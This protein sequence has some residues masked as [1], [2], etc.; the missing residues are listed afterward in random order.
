[1][2]KMSELVKRILHLTPFEVPAIHDCKSLFDL[3]PN[4]LVHHNPSNGMSAIEVQ[5][6]KLIRLL[7]LGTHHSTASVAFRQ[8]YRD[9]TIA[10]K[11]VLSKVM[12]LSVNTLSNGFPTVASLCE[13]PGAEVITV[14]EH[15]S[16]SAPT[17]TSACIHNLPRPVPASTDQPQRGV[18]EKDDEQYATNADD[19]DSSW[20]SSAMPY[21]K[22]RG[23]STVAT[24]LSDDSVFDSSV[25]LR[26]FGSGTIE[27][28]QQTQITTEGHH[29]IHRPAFI[30][31][32]SVA[33]N[34][35]P[36]QPMTNIHTFNTDPPINNEN[37][38]TADTSSNHAAA[39][40]HIPIDTD[41]R[42]PDLDD[43][44]DI[45]SLVFGLS[46]T[47]SVDHQFDHVAL[48]T[49][50][51]PGS[52][53]VANPYQCRACTFLYN[54][55]GLCP[56]CSGVPVRHCTK[57]TV[58]R[59]QSLFSALYDEHID[60]MIRGHQ[61]KAWCNPDFAETEK[62][63]EV[64]YK[65]GKNMSRLQLSLADAVSME[66]SGELV[67]HLA[68]SRIGDGDEGLHRQHNEKEMIKYHHGEKLGE[69]CCKT[70]QR[71]RRG[72]S[73]GQVGKSV[74]TVKKRRNQEY[75][76]GH[77]SMDQGPGGVQFDIL[78]DEMAGQKPPSATL[79]VTDPVNWRKHH[80]GMVRIERPS[81]G[82]VQN[83]V[84]PYADRF[85]HYHIGDVG[86]AALDKERGVN[87]DVVSNSDDR[88]FDDGRKKHPVVINTNK[89][90]F[91]NG[92]PYIDTLEGLFEEYK[93]L[94][95]EHMSAPETK[96]SKES[97]SVGLN[98]GGN[99]RI[100]A[101]RDTPHGRMPGFMPNGS[102]GKFK[103]WCAKMSSLCT[104]GVEQAIKQKHE[105][106]EM[107][108]IDENLRSEL[109]SY[110]YTL[111]GE[112]TTPYGDINAIAATFSLNT[113]A[114][115]CTFDT[116]GQCKG[117]NCGG[118][119]DFDWEAW[120]PSR[121]RK[122]N[123]DSVIDK[124]VGHVPLTWHVDK[125]NDWRKGGEYISTAC[126]TM[127]MDE[128][129]LRSKNFLLS[130]YHV[131]IDLSATD[132][133]YTRAVTRSCIEK[134]N[135]IVDHGSAAAK[136]I[137]QYDSS[138]GQ[139]F[140]Y[141]GFVDDDDVL[142]PYLKSNLKYG[143]NTLVRSRQ[144][145]NE[146]GQKQTS[147]LYPVTYGGIFAT[148]P[149]CKDRMLYLGKDID[150]YLTLV[151]PIAKRWEYRHAVQVAAA[152][153]CGYNSGQM[154]AASIM[155]DWINNK[156][157]IGSVYEHFE[158]NKNL[159]FF[160]LY[161]RSV[162]SHPGSKH[163]WV[164]E[165]GGSTVSRH[166]QGV[167]LFYH[168]DNVFDTFSQSYEQTYSKDC[169]SSL[170]SDEFDVD[171][172]LHELGR[173]SRKYLRLGRK[174]LYRTGKELAKE[175]SELWS[176]NDV[177]VLK[178]IQ[179]AGSVG[180]I[181]TAFADWADVGGDNCGSNK[182]LKLHDDKRNGTSIQTH[183]ITKKEREKK[184][185]ALH[186]E[187]SF[188]P[189]QTLRTT[190]GSMCEGYRRH[191]ASINRRAMRFMDVIF[192]SMQGEVQNFFKTA[193]Q[194][195]VGSDNR[196]CLQVLVGGKWRFVNDLLT[197]FCELPNVDANTTMAYAWSR[198]REAAATPD[199][200]RHEKYGCFKKDGSIR[201]VSSGRFVPVETIKSVMGGKEEA[202]EL[203]NDDEIDDEETKAENTEGETIEE[204]EDN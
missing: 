41:I 161:G 182:Y 38:A 79:D 29:G 35:Q 37:E 148:R 183:K 99:G 36:A 93:Y 122:I 105:G 131:G 82:K 110:C 3:I 154:M 166:C 138:E 44:A 89:N 167:G 136:M 150:N 118:V 201:F 103:V 34:P 171:K 72:L 165:M 155:E 194:A 128:I 198:Q 11:L 63:I 87:T 163:P 143:E 145:E 61:G 97:N 196:R 17:S 71:L 153:T 187:L 111:T 65:V 141:N 20:G 204:A 156:S 21:L 102:D 114:I 108:S 117:D 78:K 152:I 139:H 42:I 28:M 140:C 157:P 84:T 55:E 168:D 197:F 64:C 116:T 33:P 188:H 178:Y 6:K 85:G 60:V 199:W 158:E 151:T 58:I 18:I 177:S 106:F 50:V 14:P 31:I 19:D 66:D 133:F 180:I 96:G 83:Y 98:I 48:P 142:L 109:N 173:I 70:L 69:E 45:D 68:S 8:G 174:N 200:V 129:P 90:Y 2:R 126:A 67:M 112:E 181:D 24:T 192:L 104:H 12:G 113:E 144:W 127:P 193:T 88:L 186:G 115:P 92:K 184:F 175:V 134:K 39:T 57:S 100:S 13:S 51:C 172:W 53:D 185:I 4:D 73:T 52:V 160:K 59:E 120:E 132:I 124:S 101:W 22:E 91:Y 159:N 32:P 23:N 149:A 9:M 195:R 46:D 54:K 5:V 56:M 169:W 81:R 146:D 179:F 15:A 86:G 94:I 190:E 170:A 137:C 164:N 27:I 202:T 130:H 49:K 123:E 119:K 80:E 16:G 147:V 74:G 7:I 191:L 77:S 121:D 26:T 95:P 1:M 30:S 189:Q 107:Y 40:S 25:G 10:D 162:R 125:S 47:A 62:P 75:V 76:F 43:C 176:Y 203:V 135:V